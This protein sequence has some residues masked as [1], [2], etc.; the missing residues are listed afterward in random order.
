MYSR[1]LATTAK[2]RA[3]L[4]QRQPAVLLHGHLGVPT[5]LT[6]NDEQWLRNNY[7]ALQSSNGAV[8]GSITFTASYDRDTNRFFILGD[9]IS[10]RATA[11][12]LSGSF[13]IR[14]TER[15]N[16]STSHLP[17]FY[18]HGIDPIPAR[19]FGQ[20]DKSACLCSPFD[21]EDFLKPEFQFRTFLEQ[22]VI[23]FLYGQLFYSSEGRWPW[24][25]YTHGATGILEAYSKISN[26]GRA[27]EC[28]RLLAQD[29]NWRSI[30]SAFQQ[31]PYI[32]GHTLCFCAKPDQ[33]KRC[34][35]DA[36]AGIRRLQQDLRALRI[37]I[38]KLGEPN[39]PLH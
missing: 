35:P 5:M 4:K 17:A 37:P 39:V 22:L 12:V 8:S 3:C 9:E 11:V 28:L 34:H 2:S 29:M 25:E 33:I 30:S 19:H 38:H 16:K 27:T 6:E 15:T 31:Q 14:I 1:P 26:T 32:K 24:P 10:D 20:A 18:V 23:P 21:E 13:Q 36:L 7:A